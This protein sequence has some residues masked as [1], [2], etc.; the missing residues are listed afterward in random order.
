MTTTETLVSTPWGWT[1]DIEEL[2]EGVWRVWT[3]SHGGLKLSR[4]RWAAAP[5]LQSGDAM[6]N[7]HLRR[8]GLR[9]ANRQDAPRPRRRTARPGDGP[10][11]CGLLRPLRSGPPAPPRPCPPGIHYHAVAYRGGFGTDPFGR[12]D[13][14]ASRPSPSW[15]DA[16]MVRTYGK[17]KAVRVQPDAPALPGGRGAG[18]DRDDTAQAPHPAQHND[19]A[20]D[21]VRQPL[22][23]R[24][25][26]RGRRALRGLRLAGQGRLASR[27]ASP[28]WPAG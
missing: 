5:R 14:T 2:A 21:G 3:P 22:R 27:T 16:E 19:Q 12:F 4:E 13:T 7:A 28:S 25:D 15:A 8:G 10:E 23:H 9:G 11:G 24:L 6:F 26:G 20:P 1:H 18:H 17:L